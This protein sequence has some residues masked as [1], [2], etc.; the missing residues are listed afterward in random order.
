MG[1][2]TVFAIGVVVGIAID[3]FYAKRT[4]AAV[5]NQAARFKDYIESKLK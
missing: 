4:I 2:V 1:Y 5:E 3:F